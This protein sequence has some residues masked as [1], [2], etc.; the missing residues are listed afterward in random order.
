MVLGL[1]HAWGEGRRTG[2]TVPVPVALAF[3]MWDRR[4]RPGAP[5]E[6]RDAALTDFVDAGEYGELVRTLRNACASFRVFAASAFG[7][8]VPPAVGAAGDRPPLRWSAANSYGL[9][10]PFVWACGES[11]RLSVSKL[12]AASARLRWWRVWQVQ[13]ARRAAALARRVRDRTATDNP[14]YA[15]AEREAGRAARLGWIQTSGLALT[16]VCLVL[17]LVLG[18]EWFLHDPSLRRAELVLADPTAPAEQVESARIRLGG[19]ARSAWY[20]HRVSGLRLDRD[21]A[22]ALVA[23]ADADREERAWR[24]VADARDEAVRDDSAGQYLAT[25][26]SGGHAE[27]ARRTRAE[28][29]ERSR[30]SA[31]AAARAD[32]AETRRAAVAEIEASYRVAAVKKSE[33][34]V[35][36]ALRQLRALPPAEVGVESEEDRKARRDLEERMAA[37]QLEL[38]TDAARREQLERW[39]PARRRVVEAVEKFELKEEAAE[40]ADA[41]RQLP[42]LPELLA[43]TA[44]FPADVVVRAEAVADEM[45]KQPAHTPVRRAIDAL[46]AARAEPA[47]KLLVA[48]AQHLSRLGDLRRELVCQHD[49]LLYA[50]FAA[51]PTVETATAFK[52]GALLDTMKKEAQA[53]LDYCARMDQPQKLQLDVAIQWGKWANKASNDLLVER[54]RPGAEPEWEA[55][56]RYLEV[57]SVEG[58]DS[59]DLD[60]IPFDGTRPADHVIDV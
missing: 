21:R 34:G 38:T 56:T 54:H 22:A 50:R 9:V 5:A 47:F 59:R 10:E 18:I 8:P 4:V 58:G 36:T 13:A 29:A 16:S 41:G 20:R 52:N 45:T 17:G 48:D 49:K 28:S 43:A 3:T 25:F 55:V 42:G 53:H 14:A 15:T 2:A 6:V 12:A 46:D 32:K 40:L 24:A 51:S 11:S 39:E 33:P 57:K 7:R 26:P 44:A 27:E 37:T 1:F 35:A 60:S 23:R 31:A 30:Q 19:Y